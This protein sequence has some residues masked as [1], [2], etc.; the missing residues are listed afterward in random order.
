[1]QGPP[2]KK[3]KRKV[4]G[5]WLTVKDACVY[6]HSV[7]HQDVPCVQSMRNWMRKGREAYDGETVCLQYVKRGRKFMTK[8][9]WIN[10]FIE[11]VFDENIQG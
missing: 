11:V 1:M 5:D 3:A 7:T 9:A 10:L 8:K 2:P 6:Y 4:R